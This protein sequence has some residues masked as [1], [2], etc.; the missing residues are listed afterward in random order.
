MGYGLNIIGESG[1]YQLESGKLNFIVKQKG[2]LTTTQERNF[3]AILTMYD[4]TTEI[5]LLRPDATPSDVTA[6]TTSGSGFEHWELRKS[7]A[8]QNEATATIY[9][10]ARINGV[11]YD[12]AV[13][14]CILSRSDIVPE[15]SSTH[16][17]R[18]FGSLGELSYDSGYNLPK[19]LATAEITLDIKGNIYSGAWGVSSVSYL[20][21]NIV[22]P[23]PQFAN[24]ERY[25]ELSFFEL[26]AYSAS[27]PG[28]WGACRYRYIDT[29]F[30][31]YSSRPLGQPNYY[32][33]YG[34]TQKRRAFIMEI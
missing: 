26:L 10:L 9:A 6:S 32:Y 30:T 3:G 8:T 1:T 20:P 4:P 18:I 29:D 11:N 34:F 28:H 15:S 24:R 5:M 22:L 31:L 12:R 2:I 13:K 21:T 27:Q 17:L 33:D 25:I 19:P 7:N 23:A 16:G 14:Y